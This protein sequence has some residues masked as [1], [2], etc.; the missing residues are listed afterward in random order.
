M[1][2]LL[3]S[4]P[5]ADVADSGNS[6]RHFAWYV[7]NGSFVWRGGI[8]KTGRQFRA[9]LLLAMQSL[10]PDPVWL[11]RCRDGCFAGRILVETGSREDVE[12]ALR[13]YGSSR[14]TLVPLFA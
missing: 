1:H 3:E 5:P 11:A 10:G 6:G 13:R 9:G 7:C 4:I 12:D 2:L 14:F 8:A